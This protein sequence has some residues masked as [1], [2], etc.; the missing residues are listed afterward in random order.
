[1]VAKR[2]GGEREGQHSPQGL[3]DAGDTDDRRTGPSS[4]PPRKARAAGERTL[5]GGMAISPTIDVLGKPHPSRSPEERTHAW[6]HSQLLA[7]STLMHSLLKYAF[8]FGLFFPLGPGATWKGRAEWTPGPARTQGW[9]SQGRHEFGDLKY[10]R[11]EIF[12]CC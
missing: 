12:D 8:H 9:Y 11:K 1:M 4:H 5:A 10:R 3:V 6:V 7:R 2:C